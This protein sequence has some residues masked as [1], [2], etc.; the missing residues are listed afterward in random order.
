MSSSPATAFARI[1]LTE[2]FAVVP[3]PRDPRGVRHP[4]PGI[5]SVESAAVTAGARTLLAIG[6]WVAHADRETLTRLGI[7]LSGRVP[8]ES[9]I[10]RTLAGVDAVDLDRRLG[11]WAATRVGQRGGRRVL[12]VDGKSLRGAA[13]GGTRPH[14]LAALEHERGVVVG[15]LA[16]PDKTSGIA[17]LKDLLEPMDLIGTV[18]TTDA[19]HCQRDTATWLVGRGADYVMTVKGN[20]P[21]LRARL[22]ALPWKDVPGHTAVQAGHGRRVRRTVKAVQVPDWVDW[23]GAAQVLQIRRSRTVNARRTI[24]VVYAICSVPMT[25]AAPRLVASWI[26]GHWAIDNALHWVRDVVFDEDRHQLRVGSGPHVMATLRN[27]AIILL[28][29]TGCTSIAAELRHHGRDATRPI[30]LLTEPGS[31]FAEA[32]EAGDGLQRRAAEVLADCD[33]EFLRPLRPGDARRLRELL[34]RLVGGGGATS[35]AVDDGRAHR[36]C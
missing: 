7:G 10:R 34:T 5:L 19:L 27:T 29:L 21:R 32:L 15:Q 11:A 14:L 3:D 26:Q 4:L 2:V 23:P 9:T 16:V 1:P 31:D 13:T 30:E 22:K 33:D 12:A 28:R 17:A 8:S 25:D 18:V 20:Q 36:D 6:E 24:E 35:A